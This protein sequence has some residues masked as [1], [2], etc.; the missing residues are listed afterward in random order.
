[1]GNATVIVLDSV[2]IGALPDADQYGDQG[3]A[4]LQHL[5]ETVKKV[6]LP[7]L[8]SLGLGKIA[9]LKGFSSSAKIRGAYGKLAS[10]TAGKDSVAGHWELMGIWLEKPLAVFPNGFPKE[11]MKEFEQKTGHGWLG[12]YAASGTEI[13]KQLGQ[14]HIKTKKPIVYTS[15]DSVFQIAAHEEIIPLDELYRICEISRKICDRYLIGR[16]IARPFITE[17]GEF[18]RT[19]A[20]K[21][22]SI[23]PPKKTALNY[24]SEHKV[25]TVG[26]GKIDDLFAGSG[27]N[28]K[29]HSHGNAECIATTIQEMGSKKNSFIF[30]NLVDFDMLYGHRRDCEGYY[31][32]LKEFDEALPRIFE[33]MQG[34]DLLM[35]SA[36]HGNDPAFKGSDHTREYVPILAYQKNMKHGIPLGICD[37]FSDVGKTVL[38]YFGAKGD[39]HG[40]S[41]LEKLQAR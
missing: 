34:D 30:T 3:A 25:H 13:I 37:T 21:D 35:I 5:C 27:L 8:Q 10:K 26:I 33:K 28:E 38:E 17:K 6:D 29:L 14:E 40:K 41:F 2:G 7:H 39:I 18:K 19:A 1:M 23:K 12:N 31:K 11:L 9:P 32:A 22:Y 16:V 15:A 20:R 24:L 4:T 36:D